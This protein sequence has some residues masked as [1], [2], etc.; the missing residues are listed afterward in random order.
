[1]VKVTIADQ[2]LKRDFKAD[3]FWG[4]GYTD[5]KEQYSIQVSNIGS[6]SLHDSITIA[7]ELGKQVPEMLRDL[8][9][10]DPAMIDL[11]RAI[12]ISGILNGGKEEE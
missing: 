12:V 1:M 11:A 5:E 6:V 10:G 2:N 9:D 4:I 7:K 8:F 3:Y